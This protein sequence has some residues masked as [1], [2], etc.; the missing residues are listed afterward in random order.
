MKKPPV[1]CLVTLFCLPLKYILEGQKSIGKNH[2]KW[3]KNE[4]NKEN[5]N[6]S[7]LHRSEIALK[8][9]FL[10]VIIIHYERKYLAYMGEKR[11]IIG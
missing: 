8:E 1:F 2:K 7:I 5:M 3:E 11:D 4:R 9:R 10:C 6:K